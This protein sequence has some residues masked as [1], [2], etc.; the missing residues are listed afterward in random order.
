M[1]AGRFVP[2]AVLCVALIAPTGC[3]SR[4]VVCDCA[5]GGVQVS[6][7]VPVTQ[8][9]TTGP[10]CPTQPFCVLPL[11]GG[12]C[13]QFEIAFSAAGTCHIVATA[14]DGRRAIY[15][16]TVTLVRT[17]GCCGDVYNGS[18]AQIA[19]S[20]PPTDAGMLATDAAVND[21]A[22]GDLRGS[23]GAGAAAPDGSAADGPPVD[24]SSPGGVLL[25]PDPTGWVDRSTTGPTHIQGRWYGFAD[26]FGPDGMLASGTC[27]LAGQHAAADCS[28]LTTPSP[29]S[30]PNT[31]GR[32]CTVG[33]AARVINLVSMPTPDYN[34]IT[35]AGIAFSFNLAD[36]T[37]TPLP[38]NATANGVLGIGFDIDTV[39]LSGLRVQF[40]TADAP[41][42]P[43]W[44]GDQMISPVRAGHNEI[45]WSKV[46]GPF[47][48]LLAPAF[49]PT[50]IMRVEFLVAPSVPTATPFA[51]CI[52]NLTALV[53]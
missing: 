39:P 49:D 18:A 33:V 22:S 52:S 20:F 12:Q 40:P 21:A 19:L 44:G 4:Q 16:E 10:A 51:F 5:G 42:P 7:A 24:R 43:F 9:V 34:N 31:G 23:D 53:Q 30:F 3:T 14:A 37:A 48:D 8:I 26:G 47:Y 15:D 35:G 17:G 50:A 41:N 25:P 6:S 13:E 11:D 45:L 28:Q 36:M 27:E 1:T 2:Q 29:G 46:L 32:M 38:Y